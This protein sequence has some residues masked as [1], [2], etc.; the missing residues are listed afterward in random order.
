M[1]AKQ[2]FLG[3]TLFFSFQLRSFGLSPKEIYAQ[4]S[5]AVVLIFA[6]DGRN[7]GSSGTGSIISEKGLIITN[8]H[9][10]AK[11]NTPFSNIFVYLKPNKITGDHSKDLQNRFSAELLK[12]DYPLDLALL[13]IKSDR[14]TFPV[15][16]FVNPDDVSI[17][18]SVAAIGHPEQ[19]GLWTLTTGSISSVVANFNSVPGKDVFQTEASFNRGNS[20]GP[21]I[22]ETGGMVGVNTCIARKASDGLTITDINFSLKSGVAVQWL[23]QNGY[24]FSYMKTTGESDQ[25]NS[26]AHTEKNLAEPKMVESK[27]TNKQTEDEKAH[28]QREAV[29]NPPPKT[30]PMIVTEKR[31]YSL[32]TFI[33]K[34][35]KEM[36][37]L[38][39]MMEEMGG[40][41]RNRKKW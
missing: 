6:T 23:S 26:V 1:I 40:K 31:P 21:L 4:H 22:G 24:Q 18:D 36:K 37:E 3:I 5:Q 39:D 19:G 32:D 12:I 13:K 34:R 16:Q 38:E 27:K 17:G 8:A 30:E 20:G 10:V 28:T 7:D 9:V 15:M 25:S 33:S 35:I 11:E 2:L 14:E 29:T 41:V